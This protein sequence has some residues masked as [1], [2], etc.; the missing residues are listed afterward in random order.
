M[1][2]TFS[3]NFKTDLG[4]LGL[5]I[6]LSKADIISNNSIIKSY[7]IDSLWYE[8]N[9]SISFSI[10]NLAE[11]IDDGDAVDEIKVFY[12][13]KNNPQG[14]DIEAF[15]INGDNLNFCKY[16][17][18]FT[19][20]LP[21]S[22]AVI[23]SII[24]NNDIKFIEKKSNPVGINCYNSDKYPKDSLVTKKSYLDIQKNNVST[25]NRCNY[26]INNVGKVVS[27]DISY[28]LYKKINLF[29]GDKKGDFEE[30]GDVTYY[31]NGSST[32][33][34]IGTTVYDLYRLVNSEYILEKENCIGD[35][36]EVFIE[37]LDNNPKY[38]IDQANRKITF[39]Q[40]D[41]VEIMNSSFRGFI[42][43][44][45]LTEL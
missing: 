23:E 8:D 32:V 6:Y 18:Y 19:V 29:F 25:S 26:Y 42:T 31:V 41:L 38:I 34:I 12:K 24:S 9:N 35:I 33:D 39:Q 28:R 27:T 5:I 15:T 22:I 16:N 1:E 37:G 21:K 13:V 45:N 7:D 40:S 14:N 10:L 44:K 4:K 30:S 17:N 36:S 11:D 20:N 43:Y 2:I 3:E